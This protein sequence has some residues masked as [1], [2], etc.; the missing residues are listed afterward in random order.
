MVFLSNENHQRRS[1]DEISV[2]WSVFSYSSNWILNIETNFDV[3][4]LELFLIW[5]FPSWNLEKNLRKT[6]SQ[7]IPFL[8]LT[9]IDAF[10]NCATFTHE[11]HDTS[12]AVTHVTLR[13]NMLKVFVICRDLY[14]IGYT[15][16]KVGSTDHQKDAP[17]FT[18]ICIVFWDY[19]IIIFLV[20]PI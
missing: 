20:W 3:L 8:I 6:K 17:H 2:T 13:H 5:D 7:N 19:Y 18:L 10:F 1:C 16:S 11:T 9:T 12:A 15:Q 4:Y 14:C